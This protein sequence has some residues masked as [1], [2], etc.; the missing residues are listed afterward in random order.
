MELLMELIR[1]L[2]GAFVLS[3]QELAEMQRRIAAQGA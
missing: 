2:V 3:E 1:E